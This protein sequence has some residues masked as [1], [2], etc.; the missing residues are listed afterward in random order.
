MLKDEKN[1]KTILSFIN[2]ADINIEDIKQ[3]EK[4]IYDY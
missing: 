3:E 4:E 1:K 2:N